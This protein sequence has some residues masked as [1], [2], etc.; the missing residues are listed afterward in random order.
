MKYSRNKT[1]LFFHKQFFIIICRMK[2][3]QLTVF[4]SI[5]TVVRYIVAS[6]TVF[7]YLTQQDLGGSSESNLSFVCDLIFFYFLLPLIIQN[8]QWRRFLCEF[9]CP[10]VCIQIKPGCHLGNLYNLCHCEILLKDVLYAKS[11]PS[12]TLFIILHHSWIFI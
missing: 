3:H 8:I 7:E 12:F 5:M 11:H 9:S 2:L 10:L 4:H 6:T 1:Y